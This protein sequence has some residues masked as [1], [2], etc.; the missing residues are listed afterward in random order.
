MVMQQVT[1]LA[2]IKKTP[3]NCLN[4]VSIY[5]QSVY[6]NKMYLNDTKQK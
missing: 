4:S 3:K 2:E 6:Q 5:T 1:K